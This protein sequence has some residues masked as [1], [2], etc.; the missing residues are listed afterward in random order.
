MRPEDLDRILADE[1]PVEPSPRLAAA[2]MARVRAAAPPPSPPF[3]WPRLLL[4]N[5][6]LGAGGWL[7]LSRPIPRALQGALAAARAALD[8]ALAGL[9]DPQTA[10]VLGGAAAA[11]A[12][13]YLLVHWTLRSAGARR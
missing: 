1:S 9:G 3:P 4:G 6:A 12:G 11:L 2:V 8:R 5:A 7:V 13:T 10:L